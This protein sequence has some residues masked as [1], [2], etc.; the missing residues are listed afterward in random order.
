MEEANERALTG[1]NR[2]ESLKIFLVLWVGV[3][4]GGGM[5]AECLLKSH[6]NCMEKLQISVTLHW[7][8]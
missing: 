1:V 3:S 4:R 8:K 2:G 6:F 5:L 7:Y